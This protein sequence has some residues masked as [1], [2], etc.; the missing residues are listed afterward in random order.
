M[1]GGGAVVTTIKVKSGSSY[2]TP[3]LNQ[4]NIP[5]IPI[6][7]IPTIPY[8]KQGIATL[9]D[10]NHLLSDG[11]VYTLS[12]SAANYQWLD[13]EYMYE[14]GVYLP[15]NRVYAPNGKTVDLSFG[16]AIVTQV[17]NWRGRLTISGDKVSFTVVEGAGSDAEW[18]VKIYLRTIRGG[19]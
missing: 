5:S 18:A 13:F 7:K 12:A 4:A 17:W 8:S 14:D 2:V 3:V 19:A 11:D 6:A 10:S 16:T 9:W 1:P 15:V